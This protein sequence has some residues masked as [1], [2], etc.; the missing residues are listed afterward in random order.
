MRL[1]RS[2]NDE[3]HSHETTSLD[4][5]TLREVRRIP[6]IPSDFKTSQIFRL[7]RVAVGESLSW[8]LTP[9]HLNRTVRKKYDDGIVDHWIASYLEGKR[10]KDL[11]FVSARRGTDT[12]GLLT[13]CASSWNDTIWLLDI[14]VRE[15]AR[16]TGLGSVLVSHL[17]DLA[18]RQGVR[19]IFL[20]TQTINYPAMRF[21]LGK[22]FELA[23]IND[24]LYSNHDVERQEVAVFLFWDCGRETQNVL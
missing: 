11:R 21:Y 4:E 14:R 10:E 15:R 7:E 16:R 9:E 8:R 3:P 24:R 17:Q 2:R 18:H 1:G 20:E 5:L 22:G 23:G 19:G 6:P 12:D 13:W